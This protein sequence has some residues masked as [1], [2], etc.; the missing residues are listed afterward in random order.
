[1]GILNP[2]NYQFD[3]LNFFFWSGLINATAAFA[4]SLVVLNR[5][6][7][8]KKNVAFFL[9]SIS[10]AAWAVPYT[11]FTTTVDPNVMLFWLRIQLMAATLGALFLLYFVIVMLE[12]EKSRHQISLLLLIM[13][14]EFFVVTFFTPLII[15]T[16]SESGFHFAYMPV[17]GPLHPYYLVLWVGTMAYA[18]TLLAFGVMNSTGLVQ[19][20]RKLIF[21]GICIGV[22]SAISNYL[23]WYEVSI[24]P[25][26]NIATTLY[27]AT[28]TYAMLRYR[29]FEISPSSVAA[30]IIDTM[31]EALIIV[32]SERRISVANQ[33]TAKLVGLPVS[34]LSGKQ[35][36][37]FLPCAHDVIGRLLDDDSGGR[38]KLSI[39][40]TYLRTGGVRHIPISLSASRVS[41]G[42]SYAF[43]LVCHDISVLREKIS[44]IEAQG[45]ELSQKTDDLE[46]ANV[47][48]VESRE[49]VL[50]ALETAQ[51][52]KDVAEREREQSQ[53]ML[54]SIGD[55]VFVLDREGNLLMCNAVAEVM[56]GKI[57][58]QTTGQTYKKHFR[59]VNEDDETAS[60]D[61][62]VE[63]ME[64][65]I[66]THAPDGT[67]LLSADGKMVPVAVTAAPLVDE[68]SVFG[69]VAVMHDITRERAIDRAKT[70][71]VSIAS[72]QLRTPLSS[73]KWMLE[74][75]Y[76]SDISKLTEQQRE[77]LIMAKR[78]TVRMNKLVND[79]LNVSQIES[80]RISSHPAHVDMDALC[81]SA[82]KDMSFEAK[83][84]GLELHFEPCQLGQAYV[85][86][87]LIRNVLYNLL[88]NAIKYT[89]QG[90]SVMVCGERSVCEITVWVTDTGIGVPPEEQDR[91]FR[92]FFR[93]DNVALLDTEGYG[94]GLYIVKSVIQSSGGRVWL[95][96]E[97]GKGSKFNITLPIEHNEP[98]DGEAH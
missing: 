28:I 43:V 91:V 8:G 58:G 3:P 88:S 51:Q 55:G 36:S 89:P 61:F 31:G 96:S 41:L 10:V 94:L 80:G 20:Q 4:A 52:E 56:A 13:V 72:H 54:R 26:T 68:G 85:D 92:K 32:N 97:V 69:A 45:K 73:L 90:G 12:L 95:E 48:L 93:G 62:I 40:E 17:P 44:V 53:A 63:C 35:I 24:G 30:D 81:R 16:M 75:L 79:L 87:S 74:M 70:E 50:R 76:D 7:Y 25:Y 15:E 18:T 39:P 42:K 27:V 37:T 65:S 71:F 23:P 19:K 83:E 98:Q 1:M 60:D 78:S 5:N 11:V 6:I 38:I 14:M 57:S 2:A 34:A 46:K 84:K 47:E 9:F 67:T 33:Q 22:I 77:Y 64:S 49:D 21:I 82:V 66:V 59:F 86:A 29:L